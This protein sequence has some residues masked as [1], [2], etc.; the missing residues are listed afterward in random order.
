VLVP[1][2]LC[3]VYVC[4]VSFCVCICVCV[5][6]L[7]AIVVHGLALMIRARGSAESVQIQWPALN[8]ALLASAIAAGLM[9]L[10]FLA[11]LLWFVRSAGLCDS[12]AK[13]L[14]DTA[15]QAWIFQKSLQRKI[16]YSR[17]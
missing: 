10:V 8:P 16:A 15:P 14:P 11:G 7:S 12:H 4:R 9:V 6:I 3:A 5:I 2:H 1:A 17:K 13:Y